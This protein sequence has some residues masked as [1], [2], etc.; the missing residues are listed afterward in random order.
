MYDHVIVDGTV[1]ETD[2][3]RTPGP[4]G[5]VDLRWPRKIH[6]HGGTIQVV[7]APDDGWPLWV[8]EE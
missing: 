5:G 4:T 1:I 2:R 8:S 6:N 7:S 3:V